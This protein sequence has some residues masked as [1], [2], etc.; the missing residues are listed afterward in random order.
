M[1]E[2]GR[3]VLVTAQ[4][5]REGEEVKL[6]A[7]SFDDLDTRLARNLTGFAVHVNGP[8]AVT[9]LGDLLANQREGS[10]RIALF[11]QAD[12]A[13]TVEIELPATYALSPVLRE[14]IGALA[15]VATVQEL[16]AARAG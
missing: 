1:L 7:Q 12:D 10:G 2:P 6:S 15:G 11:V 14:E 9:P 13:G 3:A 8:D 4:A 16:A 5:R